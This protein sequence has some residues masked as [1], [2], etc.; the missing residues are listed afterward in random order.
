MKPALLPVLTLFYLFSV[1]NAKAQSAIEDK[2][3]TVPKGSKKTILRLA[4]DYSE[5]NDVLTIVILRGTHQRQLYDKY[6]EIIGNKL[7]SLAIP[8]RFFQEFHERPGTNLTYFIE[9][10]LNGPVNG[11][12]FYALL[13]R[14]ERRFREEY[15]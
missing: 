5:Q 11:N 13:P 10:D 9:N 2:I 8:H 6:I 7:D 3:I 4:G 1:C 15:K 12:E 14:I